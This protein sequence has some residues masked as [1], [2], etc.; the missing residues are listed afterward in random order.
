MF[1]PFHGLLETCGFVRRFKLGAE[2]RA[3]VI[4]YEHI[5]PKI[6]LTSLAEALELIPLRG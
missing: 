3:V 5:A 4:G 6:D 1:Q 2:G